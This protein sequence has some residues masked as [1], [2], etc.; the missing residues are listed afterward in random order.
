[1]TEGELFYHAIVDKF[2]VPYL[3]DEKGKYRNDSDPNRHIIIQ[4]TTYSDKTKF[5]NYMISTV[6]N[7]RD[8]SLM[9]N[10]ELESL[11]INSIGKAYQTVLCNI[12][13]DYA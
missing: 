10:S 2:L 13:Q 11:Y 4:P 3:L 9:S 1:M 5:V 6:F 7:G 8:L 12:L